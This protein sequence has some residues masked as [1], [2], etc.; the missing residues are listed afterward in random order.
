MI[1]RVLTLAA[2][3]GSLGFW[4]CGG[5]PAAPPAVPA[6][7]TTGDAPVAETPPDLSPVAEPSDLILV[8]RLSRPKV[9]VETLAAWA[10]FPVQLASVLPPEL[11]ELERLVA[12]DAPIEMA[13]V[14]NRDSTQKV[15]PPLVVISIGVVSMEQ[16]LAHAR[17]SGATVSDVAPGVVRVTMPDDESCALAV[18]VGPAP[19]RFVC[20]DGWQ[21]VETLLPY[22]T[23]GLP[24]REL[25]ANDL[26]LEVVAE[27][28]RRRYAQEI[29]AIRAMTGLLLRM[30]S[31]DDRRFD[32][33]LADVAYGVADELKALANEI[34]RIQVTAR[35]DTTGKALDLVQSLTLRTPTAGD[36]STTGQLLRDMGR[37]ASPPPDAFWALPASASSAAF[38]V[39]PDPAR[40]AEV[41][42]PLIE[43][44]DAYLEY[45]KVAPGLRKRTR[46][47]LEA[48]SAMG[49]PG[50]Y[51]TG[52]PATDAPA[53]ITNLGW[54][55]GV[56]NQRA[57]ALT[58]LFSD[59]SMLLADPELA[60]LLRA[61]F[62]LDPKL[63]PRMRSQ[64]VA[65]KG[66]PARGTAYRLELPAGLVEQ[67]KRL[68]ASGSPS[69]KAPQPA[70]AASI[71]LVIVPDGEQSYIAY[72][73]DQR[74]IIALLESAR[75][76]TDK[77][78]AT[79]A[80]LQP[81]KT[82]RPAWGGFWTIEATVRY[83]DEL[84]KEQGIGALT[85]MPHHGRTPWLVRV[86]IDDKAPTLAVSASASIPKAAFEDMGSLV[87]EI[88]ASGALSRL[89]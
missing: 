74:Q 62:D 39:S 11:R 22:V 26:H 80:E 79:L 58:G 31:L 19:A 52:S 20:G 66:F 64:A 53:S 35:L 23:R 49:A 2:L 38:G 44:A 54:T 85:R 51:A 48:Y 15:P 57:S 40:V 45:E 7:A 87:T 71:S 86:D 25:S 17:E 24:R 68:E 67:L 37:R 1:R 84:L 76:G 8:G 89:R 34:D 82:T 63:L 36:A 12:W 3:T 32:R 42:K 9:L 21:S 14:L 50:A 29:S 83:L 69:G 78:L 46:R 10:G 72:G 27:P 77:K 43:L 47:I 81:L 6:A 60:R 61:R 16:A 70:K 73:H 41:M 5:K 56:T 13:G 30:A 75:A 55:V 33:V 59:I 4:G 28:L 88:A 65:V 18:A